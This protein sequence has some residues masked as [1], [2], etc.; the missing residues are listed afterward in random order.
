MFMKNGGYYI[1]VMGFIALIIG[2]LNLQT[3]LISY[4]NPEKYYLSLQGYYYFL[5]GVRMIKKGEI[6]IL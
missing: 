3:Y 5:L 1:V 4:S 6:L 2:L